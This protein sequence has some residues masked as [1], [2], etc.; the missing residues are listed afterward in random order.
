LQAA[1]PHPVSR[2]SWRRS[3]LW[4]CWMLDQPRVLIRPRL[5]DERFKP[6]HHIVLPR[7][8]RSD[9]CGGVRQIGLE[10]VSPI[11]QAA[12]LVVR[13]RRCR[14]AGIGSRCIGPRHIPNL[15]HEMRARLR[16]SERSRHRQ[17]RFGQ[18]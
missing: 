1:M 10:H 13:Q 15:P 18:G 17:S 12:V 5:P 8:P 4:K 6:L 7:R 14:I 3:Q 2:I 9:Q 16:K 11:R